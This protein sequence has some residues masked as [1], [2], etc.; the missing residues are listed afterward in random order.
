V[1]M[2]GYQC[3]K[4]SLQKQVIPEFFEQTRHGMVVTDK[5]GRILHANHAFHTMTGYSKLRNRHILDLSLYDFDVASKIDNSLQK[6]HFWQGEILSKK[7]DGSFF[8]CLMDV[9]LMPSEKEDSYYQILCFIDLTNSKSDKEKM[10]Y[11]AYHDPLTQLPNRFLLSKRLKQM[12]REANVEDR[13]I[14]LLFL[15]LDRFKMINDTLGHTYGDSLLTEVA[16]RI[17]SCLR[18][19][20]IVARM[21]G[22]EFLCVLSDIENEK[23]VSIVAKKII[24][25]FA[26]PFELNGN[27]IFVTTSIGISQYPF[28]GDDVESLVTNADAAMYRAKKQ[29]RNKYEWSKVEM[30]ASAFEKLILENSLRKALE[31]NRL[32]VYYQPQV[33]LHTKKIVGLEALIRWQHPDLGLISPADFIPIAEETGLIVPI[34][35]WVLHTAC[36]QMKQW[37]DEGMSPMLIAVNLSAQQFLQKN[38]VDKV[39]GILQ[40]TELQP[41]YL[42][43]EITETTIMQDKRSAID[44]LKKLRA[45]GLRVSIDD[46]GTGYSSLNYLKELPVDTLKIDRSF[47]EDIATNDSSKAVTDAIITLAHNLGLKVVAEGVETSEQ[48]EKI[49][50]PQCDIIQGFLISRPI[51][52]EEIKRLIA[53]QY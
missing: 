46:F 3:S 36:Q 27:E 43:L 8:P 38:L 2:T 12:L 29:G 7:K 52:K 26:E 25:Q 39:R 19:K 11:M 4:Q 23:E 15:D 30:Q 9:Q 41:E 21:G 40:E 51:P 47:I 37:M 31:E 10:I 53:N 14:A 28:D 32:L 34:G 24:H 44:T 33:H 13:M 6:R 49:K 16:K 42:E 17:K 5:D 20:D 48:I 45:M 22:D 1:E 50:E 35:E 18:K